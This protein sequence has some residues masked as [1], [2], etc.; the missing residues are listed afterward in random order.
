MC[1][2]ILKLFYFIGYFETELIV[3]SIVTKLI[4]L[5]VNTK[6]VVTG[7]TRGRGDFTAVSKR[8]IDLNNKVPT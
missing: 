5:I 4:M 8:H 2:P 6:V 3:V 7:T 1:A